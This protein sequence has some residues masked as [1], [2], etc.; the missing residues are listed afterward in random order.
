MSERI[1]FRT[2]AIADARAA[3]AP[4]AA[5]P[6]EQVHALARYT[7]ALAHAGVD[8][9]QLRDPAMSDGLLRRCAA[10][11]AQA[12]EGRTRV[13]V[14]ERAHVAVVSGADGVHLR[15]SGMPAA[16]AR[17]VVGRAL[18]GRSVHE[19]DALE[20]DEA[21]AVDYLVF[22]TVFPSASK[23][24]GHPAVG[25]DALART[26]RRHARPVLAVGGMTAA[27]CADVAARGA[28]GV[29]AIGVFAETWRLGQGALDELVAVMH[30]AFPG[31]EAGS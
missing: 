19:D 6:A 28:A 7:A 2:M 5:P 21:G 13:V 8:V 18:V 9:V 30:A 1:R 20:P 16:R 29:A 12:A 22:G 17:A 3:G 26:C 31:A 4:D 14:N 15:A 27:R 24:P 25:L 23:A 11:M 10:G